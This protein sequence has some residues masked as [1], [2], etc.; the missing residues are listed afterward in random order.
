MSDAYGFLAPIY[1]PLS[2]LVFGKDLIQANQAFLESYE[3]KK[4]L[5]IGGGDGVAYRDFSGNLHGE[6]WDL[7]S[8]M[9]QLAK[10]NLEGSNLTIH[11]GAWQ[12]KGKFDRIFLPFVVDS[13]EEEQLGEFLI[14]IR[15]CLNSE[16][17]VIISDFF[18]PRTFL[19]RLVHQLMIY[20]FRILAKHPRKD[21]PNISQKMKVAGF[22]LYQE[23]MWRKGWIRSQV[24]AGCN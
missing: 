20:G 5:I 21:L 24:Y 13:L 9:C 18:P 17:K 23:R 4:V 14:Q 12:G 16:G 6:Y 22:S 8:R 11:I 2:Q 15:Q 19:Q 3:G 1:Q 10:K 7:S